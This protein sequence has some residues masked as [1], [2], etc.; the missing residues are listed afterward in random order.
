M[1]KVIKITDQEK[2]K[3][4]G[5]YNKGLVS[6][7]IL[8]VPREVTDIQAAEELYNETVKTKTFLIDDLPNTYVIRLAYT[9]KK[10]KLRSVD[11]EFL[12]EGEKF[13]ISESIQEILKD[14]GFPVIDSNFP[15][16]PEVPNAN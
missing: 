1:S 14:E 4:K 6:L 3:V 15:Q 13:E 11:P 7:E 2:E 12:E 10:N 5:V 9:E 8:K 16:K